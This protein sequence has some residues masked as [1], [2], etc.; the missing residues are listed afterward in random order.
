MKIIRSPLGIL[1]ALVVLAILFATPAPSGAVPSGANGRVAFMSDRSGSKQIYVM[2]GDGSAVAQ[3]TSLGNNWDPAFSGDGSLIAFISDRN[4]S[5]ELYAMNADGSTQT[6]LT[7]NTMTESR[8]SWA[9]NNSAIAFAALNGTDSDIWSIKPN[10]RGLIDLT[11]DPVAFDANP[12]WSPG[13]SNIAFDSTNRSGDPGT[14]IWTMSNTG[15]NLKQLTTT[16]KDSNPAYGPDNKTIAF[17]SARDIEVPGPLHFANVTKPDGVAVTA[18]KV[19][20]TQFSSDKVKAIDSSGTL[21]NFAQLPLTGLSVE[22]YIAVSSGLGGFPPG[23]IYATVGQNTY[24]ITPDGS[25]VTLFVNIPS[26]PNGETGI[27]F[28]TVGTFGYK[29][30]LT[31]RRGPVWTV[32]SSGV[33]TQLGDVGHQVEGPIVAPMSFAP[34]GGEIIMGNDLGNTVYAMDNLANL[35]IVG[36]WNGGE[37]GVLIPS[38]VCN[39]GTSTGAYFVAMMDQNEIL[40]FSASNFSG[41]GGDILV[42]SETD[43]VATGIGRFHSNG[44]TVSSS[45]FWNNFGAPQVEGSAFAPCPSRRSLQTVTAAPGSVAGPHE[46]YTMVAK[47]G[48][49]QTRLTSNTTDDANPAWSPDGVSILFQSDRDD[50]NQ[51]TCEGSGT[52]RY[53]VY[54]MNASNGTGQTNITNNLTANDVSPDWESVA[55]VV[56]VLDFAF[57]PASVKPAQGGTI[58]WDFTGPSQHTATDSSGM[59]LFDSGTKDPGGYFAFRFVAAGNYNVVCTIHT[60]M[61]GTIKV[62]VKAAPRSGN[63][64]TTFTITWSATSPP[65]GYV[66]DVQIF[67]P[68]APDWADWKPGVKTRSATFVSDTGPG[69]Y[70]FRGRLRNT[71]NGFFSD[72]SAPVSI[73]VTP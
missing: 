64:T 59:G 55:G 29:M 22:R 66:F 13:G 60:F 61:T 2:R 39:F 31:D 53:E 52:C 40:K 44:T 34:F 28:D 63:Q 73:T 3:L 42:P 65:A 51:P 33:A 45:T 46:I 5:P 54:K 26:M 8:P 38:T 17:E 27:T 24:Q 16:G 19:L 41:L 49:N 20:V 57:S 72:Y 15:T 23:Y 70:S 11:P 48:S 71:V 50:P 62:P 68:G 9:P 10:G 21:T 35:S 37:G 36:S 69:T 43:P 6:R 4:G 58:L 47:D 56:T 7:T 67:R 25:I 12:S 1:T 14:N 32:D 30:I 18:D